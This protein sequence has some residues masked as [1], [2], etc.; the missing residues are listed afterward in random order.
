MLKFASNLT[1]MF[2]EVP[3]LDRFDAARD[4]GFNGVEFLFP[5]DFPAHDV[6]QRVRDNGLTQALF[7]LP[8]GDWKA[9]ERGLGALPGR[10]D[11]FKASVEKA[12]T[13]AEVTGCKTLH[14][15]AGIVVPNANTEQMF[16]TFVENLIA[17]ADLCADAGITIVL[18]AL[19]S[20]D[21]PGY[22]LPHIS[23]A[24]RV[25]QA[26]GRPNIGLQFDFYHVQIMDGDLIRNFDLYL[27]DIDHIQVSSVQGRH[28]PNDGEINYP[29]IFEYINASAYDGWIGCEYM[30]AGATQDGLA[31]LDAWR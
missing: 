23:D 22:F 2:N 27:D 31:W 8:P 20:Q 15:M 3:F 12:L 26:V 17:A 25:A 14:A 10:E 18:E 4:A 5:Y 19:N 28:E 7:N 9:G 30:P 29:F 6:G 1:M 11:E 21:A 13:Y 24:A 16:E